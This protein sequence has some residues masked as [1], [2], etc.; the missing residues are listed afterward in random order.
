MELQFYRFDGYEVT[1][2]KLYGAEARKEVVGGSSRRRWDEA[3][4]FTDAQEKLSPPQLAS[5]RKLYDFATGDADRISWGTGAKTGSF[6]PKYDRISPRSVYT[7][8]SDGRL[9][10]N[11]EWL[12]DEE[13]RLPKSVTRLARHLE[14]HM[15]GFTLPE[16]FADIFVTIPVDVWAPQVASLINAIR[17]ELAAR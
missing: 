8:S 14:E 3:T 7:A 11:F 2:P 9:S 1:I 13:K 4:Y 12:R 6:N 5:L 10:L 17:E 16:N 15:T